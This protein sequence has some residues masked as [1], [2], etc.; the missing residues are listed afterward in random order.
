MK[1]GN[2][3]KIKING[4]KLNKHDSLARFKRLH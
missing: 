3:L 4:T 1:H 2:R